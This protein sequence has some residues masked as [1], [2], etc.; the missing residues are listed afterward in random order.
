MRVN[1]GQYARSSLL[2]LGSF[3]L[4]FNATT[5]LHEVGHVLSLWAI[6]GRVDRI[7]LHPF[8]WSYTFFASAPKYPAFVTAS[9]SLFGV[10]SGLVLVAVVRRLRAAWT[11]PV[12]AAGVCCVVGNGTYLC[13]D[14]IMQGGGDATSLV[15]AGAPWGVVFYVALLILLVGFELSFMLLPRVG[16]GDSVS[17]T[18][19]MAVLCCGVGAYFIGMF[20]HN[21]IWDRAAFVFWLG[22]SVIFMA[23]LTVMT[24]L[25]V[26][27]KPRNQAM[28][29]GG[30][31]YPSWVSAICVFLLGSF[32][33]ALEL[34][35]CPS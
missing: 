22:Y 11:A 28:Y 12:L 32:V 17:L 14:S 10:L 7:A 15:R 25:S 2:L 6:G 26:R 3:A 30:N 20:V 23:V 21:L 8:S 27:L 16:V 33:V 35:F 13:I 4:G 19:R 1:V 34:A 31:G 24:L 5:L 9:G 18:G 29:S